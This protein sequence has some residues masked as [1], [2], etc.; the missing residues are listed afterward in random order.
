MSSE[1]LIVV[2]GQGRVLDV[3][4]SLGAHSGAVYGQDLG[5]VAQVLDEIS[6]EIGQGGFLDYFLDVEPLFEAVEDEM[7]EPED[8]EEEI[9]NE[10]M[11]LDRAPYQSAAE[12][13]PHVRAL[14]AHLT[15]NEAD[16]ALRLKNVYRG[17]FKGTVWDLQVLEV[18]LEEAARGGR[19]FFLWTLA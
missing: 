8:D 3:P 19:G 13:L 11:V 6:R 14:L 7:G 1:T 16:T 15:S 10:Q 2:Q 9:R 5:R 4:A 17:T 18:I 12:A